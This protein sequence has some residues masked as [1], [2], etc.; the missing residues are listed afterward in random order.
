MILST[1]VH[2]Y[3]TCIYYESYL[4]LLAIIQE[5]E[6]CPFKDCKIFMKQF[7][8]DGGI[9]ALDCYGLKITVPKKAI[10]GV[11]IKIQVSASLLGSF[12]IPSDYH[13]VSPY[14]WIAADYVFKKQIQIEFQHHADVSTF[15]DTSN[16]CI[17]K[18]CSHCTHHHQ[19]YMTEWN[20]HY[21]ISNTVCT[22]YANQ[23]CSFCLASKSDQI[24]DRIVAYHYLPENYE[25]AD[26]FRAEIC[27]CY[28]L[29]ICKE[30]KSVAFGVTYV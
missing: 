17:L 30:V 2:S 5:Q 7:T 9:M 18:A 28:D 19:L 16:L 26:T 21:S 20:C 15:K 6:V 3:S 13:P 8:C 25:S 29:D 11:P 23:F 22:L 10:E 12:D 24:P 4:L 14:I 1:F 27:F